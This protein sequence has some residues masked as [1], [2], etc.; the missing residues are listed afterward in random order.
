MF[1][2]NVQN[3]FLTHN[4]TVTQ[5]MT[6]NY[7]APLK[8]LVFLCSLEHPLLASSSIRAAGRNFCLDGEQFGPPLDKNS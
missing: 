8:Y 2:L 4:R 5:S 3:K 6:E 1:V 7:C